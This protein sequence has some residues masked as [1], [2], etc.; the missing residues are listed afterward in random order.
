MNRIRLVAIMSLLATTLCVSAQR[1]FQG[2]FS[3]E[4]FNIK[5]EVNLYECDIPIPGFE[6]DSCYAYIQGRINEQ[7]MVIRVNELTETKAVV[8]AVSERGG[9]VQD[10]ELKL[11][12]DGDLELR[13]IGRSYIKCIGDG[14]Y[15]SMPKP[16]LLKRLK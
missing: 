14:K 7:W 8:R 2:V 11:T 6:I 10:I 4:Q 12:K 16:L 1:P 15:V 13:Q 9:D 5:S 3:N